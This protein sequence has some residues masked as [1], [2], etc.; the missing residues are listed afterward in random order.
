MAPTKSIWVQARNPGSVVKGLFVGAWRIAAFV[1]VTG[2]FVTQFLD[3]NA[4]V[5]EGT[6]ELFREHFVGSHELVVALR[7]LCDD[8][9]ISG[10]CHGK[11]V[12]CIGDIK[13]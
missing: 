5:F 7:E 4:V 11:I 9:S 2:G 6:F 3:E 1:V 12:Q 13:D 10:S 8:V